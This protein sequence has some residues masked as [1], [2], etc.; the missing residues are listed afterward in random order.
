MWSAYVS[1][2]TVTTLEGVYRVHSHVRCWPN[3]SCSRHHKPFRPEAEGRIALPQHE[4]G[5]DVIALLLPI[6]WFF[7]LAQGV[8][9]QHGTA[10]P[11]LTV[12]RIRL[13][14]GR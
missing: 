5:L 9:F 13:S 6:L 4:F 11:C 12:P 7:V 2:R 14:G 1:H 10:K 8:C 3:P